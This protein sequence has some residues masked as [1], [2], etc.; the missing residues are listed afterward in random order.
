MKKYS[1][2]IFILGFASTLFAQT[3]LTV[4][5]G[6]PV[7]DGVTSAGEWTSTPLVTPIGVT[8]NAMADGQFLYLSAS[9][10]DTTNNDTKKQWSFDGTTWTQ[11][12]DEDRI[13]FVWDMGDN[14][15]DGATCTQM[16]HGDGLM[17]TTT[18]KV[19]VW[20]WK[21]ARTNPMGF[22]DD[23]HWDT[24]DRQ[25]DPGIKA[26]LD[27][28]DNGNGVPNFMASND[29]NSNSIFLTE[30]QT[31]QNVFD[32][33]SVI[34]G[35][36]DLA[37][38]FDSSANFVNGDVIPGYKLQI[39]SGDRASVQAAGKHENGV[40]TVEFKKPYAGTDYDFEVVPG[41]SVEFT[42]E[43]FNNEGKWHATNG[44]NTTVYTL[45]FSLLTSIEEPSKVLPNFNLEQNFPNPFNPSTTINYELQIT[46]HEFATL[47]IF[48][49]LGEKVK[50]FTLNKPQGSVI[51]NGTNSVGETVSSGIYF[52]TLVAGDFSQTR[53][54]HFLK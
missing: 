10:A 1:T 32:P 4:T 40:W 30:D 6:T 52:Y 9:W 11:D 33:F 35:N 22:V 46:N 17:R 50:E 53:K 16:C 24:T 8:I 36:E 29:P 47:T 37:I 48:N 5:Q 28:S 43:I 26:Y 44:L 15:A 20:H 31:A 45:D 19:D 38:V 39:P 13:A 7:L 12:G 21:A 27:N 51:W 3:T 49:I 23:K 54:M 2:I 34:S 14:G 25:S 18:G 41:S 42:H